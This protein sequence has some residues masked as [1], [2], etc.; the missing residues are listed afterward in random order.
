[1][2]L[3]QINSTVLDTLSGVNVTGNVLASSYVGGSVNVTGNVLAN[4]VTAWA[5][6]GTITTA[7]QTNI[8][9]LHKCTHWSS[10]GSLP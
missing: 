7:N 10:G 4:T 9:R 5:L 2:P 6:G 8:T 1:M 3:T